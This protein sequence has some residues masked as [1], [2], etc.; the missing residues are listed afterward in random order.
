MK[1]GEIV[2]AQ[3]PQADGKPKFRPVLLLKQLPSYGDWL[4]CGIS[5]QLKQ[6]VRDFDEKVLERDEDSKKSGLLSNSVIRL[7]FL[8]V[9]PENSI[10][11]SIG[12]IAA[13]RH[14]KSLKTLT[15]HLLK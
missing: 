11:G 7:A 6:F 14:Q 10:P 5:S 4:V 3:I 13:T 12:H 15:Q 1:E 8:A 2:I 9:L